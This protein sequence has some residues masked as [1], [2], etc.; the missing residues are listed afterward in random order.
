MVNNLPIS[1]SGLELF[2]D[3]SILGAHK[4]INAPGAARVPI[5]DTLKHLTGALLFLL[6]TCLHAG[7]PLAGSNSLACSGNTYTSIT[8]EEQKIT[9]FTRRHLVLSISGERA[10]IAYED[11]EPL[12]AIKT[13]SHFRARATPSPDSWQL[14]HLDRS[15]LDLSVTEFSTLADD[16]HRSV[17]FRGSCK[18]ADPV[19]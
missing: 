2:A 10:D 1:A 16:R 3:D 18:L 17:R 5:G 11:G 8:G 7:E 4:Q 19:T 6:T 14:I 13:E 9:R 15:S 12:E